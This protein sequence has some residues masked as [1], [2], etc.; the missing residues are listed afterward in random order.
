[1]EQEAARMV[2]QSY[3]QSRVDLG[4]ERRSK[5]APGAERLKQAVEQLEDNL[6]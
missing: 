5:A 3:V 6:K 2:Q 4:E 1:M